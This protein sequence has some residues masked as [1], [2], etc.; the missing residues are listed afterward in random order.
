M[1]CRR[2]DGARRRHHLVGG[3]PREPS[4]VS[5]DHIS[6]TALPPCRPPGTLQ[7]PGLK[8]PGRSRGNQRQFAK[9]RIAAIRAAFP[10]GRKCPAPSSADAHPPEALLRGR[11]RPSRPAQTAVQDGSLVRPLGDGF[12]AHLA[13]TLP[14]GRAPES[15]VVDGSP[16]PPANGDPRARST[17]EIRPKKGEF[18]RFF[19][20][21]GAQFWGGGGA[22]PT[23]LILLRNQRTPPAP[24]RARTTGA[25]PQPPVRKICQKRRTFF[26]FSVAAESCA[27]GGGGRRGCGYSL[28][29]CVPRPAGAPLRPPVPRG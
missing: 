23:T 11:G 10:G 19:G 8:T 7:L 9:L 2:R 25:P 6:S 18:F 5:V 26:L 4:T 14:G 1:G 27:L 29:E 15:G 20:P 28:R 16:H 21:C 13:G 24:S 22:P 17:S 12:R 3:S